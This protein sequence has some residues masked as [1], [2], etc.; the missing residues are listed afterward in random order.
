ME[1]QR[2][3]LGWLRAVTHV[4]THTSTARVTRGDSP[5]MVSDPEVLTGMFVKQWLHDI[6][7]APS[8]SFS[9]ER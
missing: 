3:C 1:I 2:E 9:G 7:T 8:K 5:R 4:H 6:F